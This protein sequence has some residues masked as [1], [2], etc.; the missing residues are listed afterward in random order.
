VG[1]L[2]PPPD[3]RER[4][5]PDAVEEILTF[6]GAQCVEFAAE[7]E[8]G[9]DSRQLLWSRVMTASL[10]DLVLFRLYDL[11]REERERIQCLD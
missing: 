9:A 3:Q 8:G 4:A 6:L 2:L 10:I 11:S 5:Y 7:L 1:G